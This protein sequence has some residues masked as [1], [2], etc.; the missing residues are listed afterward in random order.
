MRFDIWG[1]ERGAE[2]SEIKKQNVSTGT[3]EEEGRAWGPLITGVGEG[4]H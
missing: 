3:T 4:G 2:G 1:S